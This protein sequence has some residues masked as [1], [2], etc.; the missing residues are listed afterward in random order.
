M[1]NLLNISKVS[2]KFMAI[3][4]LLFFQGVIWAQEKDV[5]VSLNIDKGSS[6]TTTQWYAEPWMWIVGGAVF[7]IIVIAL[8]RGN[9]K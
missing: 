1:K 6:T 5:D 8:V 3:M 9:K 4:L 7:L 2:N